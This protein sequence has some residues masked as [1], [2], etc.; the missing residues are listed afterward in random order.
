M[1]EEI[2][3]LP[4]LHVTVALSCVE[5]IFFNVAKGSLSNRDSRDFFKKGQYVAED[6]FRLMRMEETNEQIS[7]DFT[8][9]HN[10]PTPCWHP[11]SPLIRQ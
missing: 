8:L 9:I 6:N 5:V 10:P 1:T 2:A 3:L 4:S 11:V 7:N